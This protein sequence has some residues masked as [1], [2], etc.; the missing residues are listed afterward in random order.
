MENVVVFDLDGTLL[1]SKNEIIGG[2]DTIQLL[3]QLKGIG[4]HLAICTG[5][6]DHDIV[7]IDEKYHLGITE[8]ISQNG[9]VIYQNNH[10]SASLLDKEEAIQIFELLTK[11]KVRVEMNTVSNRYW[12]NNRDPQFPREL[13]D[14]SYIDPCYEE[15]IL[16]QPVV[17]F[18]IVGESETLKTIQREILSQ[19]QKVDAILTSDTSLEIIPLGV[20]K[21]SAIQQMY[22][23]STVYAIGDSQSDQSMAQHAKIFYYANKEGYP[24]SVTVSSIKEAL[25]QI[26]TLQSSNGNS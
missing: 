21:G 10:V 18:L 20:S 16:Y 5:R 3:N 25:E 12:K 14:S 19:F 26:I 9:A 2:N 7:K 23:H 4:F 24:N 17:L 11:F 22:P 1:N 13:Y 8:R 15:R 6:L